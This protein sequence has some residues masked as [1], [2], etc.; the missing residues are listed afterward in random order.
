MMVLVHPKA[1]RNEIRVSW[2]DDYG[3][4]ILYMYLAD[5]DVIPVPALRFARE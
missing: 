4:W 2:A 1:G 5:E 3:R